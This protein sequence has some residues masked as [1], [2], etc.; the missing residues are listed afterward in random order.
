MLHTPNPVPV[1]RVRGPEAVKRFIDTQHAAFP[2]LR[3]TIQDQIVEGDKV[4]THYGLPEGA[5]HNAFGIFISRVADDGKF[6]EEWMVAPGW[7][8]Q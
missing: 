5:M 4:V 2:G 7:Q 8:L 3:F 6:A 1:A